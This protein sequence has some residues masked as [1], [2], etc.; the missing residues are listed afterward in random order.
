MVIDG[1]T[2]MKNNLIVLEQLPKIKYQLEQLSTEIKEKVDRVNNLIVNE[3]TVKETKQLR[4]SLNKEFNELEEQRKQVKN[5][6]M[7]KY[8]EFN[9][10]YVECV[11][12]LYKDADAQLKSKID[13]VENKLKLEKEEELREFVKQHCEANHIHIEFEIIGLNITLSASMKS[14]KEQAK[15][16]ID[17]VTNDLK[18]IEMEEY[19]DEILLEY[20][21]TYDFVTAKTNV[22]ERHKQLEE[23]AKQQEIKQQLDEQDKKVEEVVETITA[24]KE[25]IEEDEILEAT[26]T[27]KGTKEQI[28]KLKNWLK[29]E[30]VEYE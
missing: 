13:D 29:E 28:I 18:L 7:A 24:P 1:S 5:A 8:D 11:S 26:F 19:K 22:I 10:I 12:N 9:E 15:A 20:N 2:Q 25:V 3:D 30:G 16:F 23:I 14:L 27:V 17:R 21:K 6:I 4:A